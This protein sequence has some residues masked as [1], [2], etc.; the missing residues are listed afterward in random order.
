VKGNSEVSLEERIRDEI[1]KSGRMTFARFME[2][3]LYDPWQGY[4]SHAPSRLGKK[5]D[6]FTA[7]DVGPA[8]GRCMARQVLEIDRLIGPF[9]TFHIIEFGCGRGL[10]ARDLL[11]SMSGLDPDLDGRLRYLMVDSSAAM[12]EEAAANAPRATAL[13]PEELG[14]GYNGAVLA[15]ELFDALPVHRLRRRS[16]KLVEIVIDVDA[17]GALV[18]AEA[19]PLPHVRE[20]AAR[21]GAA[22]EE[23][24]VAEVAPAT[25]AQLDLMEQV[26]E[27]GLLA[28]FDYGYPA[29]ELYDSSRNCGTLLA[30]SAHSTTESFLERVGE[31]D[32]TAHVN[33]TAIE[34]R[35]EERGLASLGLTTQDRF[36]IGNGIIDYFEQESESSIHDPQKVKQ[37]L[38]AMQLIHPM[39]MGRIFKVLMLAKGCQPPPAL[40]GM[41][42]P[43]R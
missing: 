12:R 25:A 23:G 5:G 28:I 9:D 40:S 37:R 24:A 11:D 32:L 36:L 1:R 19:E 21:Y 39:G 2:L 18:E 17:A 20:W 10:L 27:R 7:S 38:Q 15:V 6:F 14:R 33:F 35:A 42:D 31:Q 34:E 8:F 30:Y 41:E 26:I 16:G 22:A 13:A 29:A 3:A 4:Y 43:F